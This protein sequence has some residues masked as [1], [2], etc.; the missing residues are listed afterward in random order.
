MVTEA[1]RDA[2]AVMEH[3]QK[4]AE[5]EQTM[6]RGAIVFA[7]LCVIVLVV[8]FMNHVSWRKHS[9]GKVLHIKTPAVYCLLSAY[10]CSDIRWRQH[11]HS[12]C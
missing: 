6:L 12:H 5:S 1:V 4:Q 2:N 7:V 11:S 10:R 8:L 9:M 3:L